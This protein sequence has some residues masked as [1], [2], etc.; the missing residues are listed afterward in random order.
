MTTSLLIRFRMQRKVKQQSVSMALFQSGSELMSLVPVTTKGHGNAWGLAHLLRPCWDLRAL[1]PL[2]PCRSGWPTLPPG[3]M[4]MSGPELLPRVMSGSMSLQRPVA[5]E[6]H[7]A[8]SDQVSHLSPCR[9]RWPCCRR[10]QVDLG[11]LCFHLGPWWYSKPNLQLRARVCVDICGSCC[12]QRTVIGC[13]G[14]GLQPVALLVSKSLAAAGAM[15]MC[16]VCAAS[17]G[18]GIV[19]ALPAARGHVW[20]RNFG[21]AGVWDPCYLRGA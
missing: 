16:T 9:F 19:Q 10:D 6:A 20:V 18:N 15:L 2:G 7:V 14:S 5:T 11:G 17:Q 4:M 1:L 8:A 12:V 3:D 13:L 21:I